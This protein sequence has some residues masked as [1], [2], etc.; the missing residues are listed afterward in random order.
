MNQ[1]K[2]FIPINEGFSCEN[3][4]KQI[5]K[6]QGTFRNHCPFCLYSKHVDEVTPGDRK[7]DCGG[8]MKPIRVEKDSKRE[9]M[10]VH[11]CLKCQKISRNRTAADDNKDK[12]IKIAEAQPRA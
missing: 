4:D 6:A 9:W 2:K 11:Q 7:S 5:P 12:L 8:L 3:C 1:R 10:I